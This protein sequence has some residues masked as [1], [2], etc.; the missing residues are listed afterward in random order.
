MLS[1]SSVRFINSAFRYSVWIAIFAIGLG[2]SLSSNEVRSKEQLEFSAW[3]NELDSQ[4]RVITE[5]NKSDAI[6]VKV[7]S[8]I[9]TIPLSWDILEE[10]NG[11]LDEKVFRVMN[12][13]RESELPLT[14]GEAPNPDEGSLNITVSAPGRTVHTSLN[15]N[16]VR[17]NLKIMNLL[18][19]IEIYS[20]APPPSPASTPEVPEEYKLSEPTPTPEG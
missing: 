4:K 14:K 6:R 9:P 19:I 15:E 8:N 5:A 3:V 11:A 16:Q 7:E 2:Y 20:S 1:S 18:K 17:S 12:L 13:L 10:S